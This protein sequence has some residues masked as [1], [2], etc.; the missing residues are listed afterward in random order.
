MKVLV[1]GAGGYIGR[2]V[3]SLLHSEGDE[4]VAATRQP[5]DGMGWCPFDLSRPEAVTVPV[6][7]D[8]VLHLAADTSG[9]ARITPADEVASARALVAQAR[10]AGARLVF[11]SSQTAREDS[12]TDYGRIKWEIEREFLA[13]GGTVV[14]PGQVYGGASRALFGTLVSL[15]RRLPVLPALVPAPNI[16]PVHVDDLAQAVVR[17]GKMQGIGARVLRVAAPQPLPFTEFLRAIARHR[18]R[19]TRLFLP[20]PAVLVTAAR[21]ASF[22][23]IP[24]LERLGSLLSLPPMQTGEDLARLGL[25]LR[26]LEQGMRRGRGRRRAL[27]SESR[28]LLAYVLGEP[29]GGELVRRQVRAVQA[30]R[31]ARP[32]ALPGWAIGRPWLLRLFDDSARP[33]EA[34]ELAW[35]LDCATALAEA[36]PQ[37]ARR[38]LRHGRPSGLLRAFV[39]LSTAVFSE[40]AGRILR[41]VW[42]RLLAWRQPA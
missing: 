33:G 28:A 10:A 25:E 4:V 23:R 41:A 16:Q 35:R 2:R 30:L 27:V 40:L 5:L 38:F 8:L 3:A 20:I 15:V 34:T 13:A 1:T 12:P 11:V 21:R 39:G 37:G 18:L 7:T 6:G 19:R 26:S 31:A 24:A 17:A 42:R 32:L 36:S 29:P 22:H 14:R 9:H